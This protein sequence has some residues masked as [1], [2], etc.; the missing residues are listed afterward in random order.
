MENATNSSKSTKNPR[1]WPCQWAGH[2][3]YWLVHTGMWAAA[4]IGVVPWELRVCSSS[5]LP[6]CTLLPSWALDSSPSQSGTLTFDL[7]QIP[8][9]HVCVLCWFNASSLFSVCPA[10]FKL[11]WPEVLIHKRAWGLFNS[12][13][14]K[15]VHFDYIT[16]RG[17]LKF[18][19]PNPSVF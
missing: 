14:K 5:V 11:V 3:P 6:R 2:F 15:K 17:E 9:G 4:Q 18:S 13:I 16:A 12:G 8:A 19:W 1:M 10:D 7:Y